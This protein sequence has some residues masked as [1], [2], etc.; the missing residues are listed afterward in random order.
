MNR[1]ASEFTLVCALIG[2]IANGVTGSNTVEC[3]PWPGSVIQGGGETELECFFVSTQS[4]E[5][6]GYQLDFPCLLLSASP[7]GGNLMAVDL[8]YSTAGSR[9]GTYPLFLF[10]PTGVTT[11]E[12]LCTIRVGASII[13]P[14]AVIPANDERYVG[15]I[16][17]VASDCAIGEFQGGIENF[18]SPP[19][20]T[21]GTRFGGP[22]GSYLPL[23]GVTATI[24]V[25]DLDGDGVGD[26]CD[27]CPDDNPDDSDFDGVCD[28][29]DNCPAAANSNQFDSDGDTVGDVCDQCPGLDDCV[30]INYDAV[31]D[32]SLL[33]PTVSTWGLIILALSLLTLAKVN[34]RQG[35]MA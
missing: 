20:P 1:G 17:Y 30:D 31:P 12:T 14:T 26:T 2:I 4:T 13:K 19:L 29:I 21:D 22:F 33:I 32:C 27:P 15:T 25:S 34:R 11:N 16:R 7:S 6:F 23:T 24:I 9:D 35:R 8:F 5:V 28:S 10:N 3:R 18:S